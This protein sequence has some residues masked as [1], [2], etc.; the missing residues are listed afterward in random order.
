MV[1]AAVEFCLPPG[2]A[3]MNA[4]SQAFAVRSTR[5]VSPSRLRVSA[6]RSTLA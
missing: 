3:L 2:T 5:S 1:R 4:W 6:P